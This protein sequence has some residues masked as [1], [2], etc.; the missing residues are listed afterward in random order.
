VAQILQRTKIS[1]MGETGN[2]IVG[3]VRALIVRRWS[4]SGWCDLEAIVQFSPNTSPAMLA[5]R[6]LVSYPKA[7]KFSGCSYEILYAKVNR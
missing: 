4:I 2:K 1:I 5:T 3:E 7:L 6:P